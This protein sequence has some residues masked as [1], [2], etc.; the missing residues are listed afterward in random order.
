MQRAAVRRFLPWAMQGDTL[1][2]PDAETA[3]RQFK[4]VV[5]SPGVVSTETF[6]DALHEVIALLEEQGATRGPRQKEAE[7]A[8]PAPLTA[9]Q[10]SRASRL[11]Q[12]ALENVRVSV[13]DLS[14]VANVARAAIADGRSDTDVRAALDAFIATIRQDRPVAAGAPQRALPVGPA[15]VGAEHVRVV[16]DMVFVDDAFKDAAGGLPGNSVE[17]VEGR[18]GLR[19]PDG[20]VSFDREGGAPARVGMTYMVR[21]RPNAVA[22]LL[23]AMGLGDLA[24]GRTAP[25][26]LT[27]APEGQRTDEIIA[28]RRTHIHRSG[29]DL[30]GDSRLLRI[31]ADVPGNRLK[32]MGGG[33]FYVVTPLGEIEF[34]RMRGV[35][36]L[37]QSGRS[38]LLYGD[39]NA[40]AAA[41]D[42]LGLGDLVPGRPAQAAAAPP[43]PV[44]R[45]NA[46]Y[47]K[48][49]RDEWGIAV[50]GPAPTPGEKIKVETRKGKVK[51]EVV[52]KVIGPGRNSKGQP[53]TLCSIKGG[54]P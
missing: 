10:E 15:R 48:L 39:A 31:L 28:E 11:S 23:D 20:L 4:A 18:P 44:V 49:G 8:E 50:E 27:P 21:G 37:S 30:Y 42:A 53:A 5:S 36:F 2:V 43:A 14:K 16:V 34:D 54:E 33:E 26:G 6:M 25:P 35:P 40:L 52:D 47:K 32:D 41:L 45:P 19:T 12:A 9:L 24:P 46:E 38:H 22:A 13:L 7:R 17:M 51:V 3:I 1:V 29:D